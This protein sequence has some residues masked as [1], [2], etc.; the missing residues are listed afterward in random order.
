[1]RADK[2]IAANAEAAE[3]GTA[4]AGDKGK[5]PSG[6]QT[7][8]RGLDIL[9][10]VA[11][12][13]SNL[14]DIAAT[15]GLSRSTVHRLAATLVDQRYLGFARNMGYTLGPKLLELGFLAG[16]QLSLPRIARSHLEELAANSGDTVHLAMLDGTRA[17]YLDK[18]PGRRR[19]EISSRIGERQ[20]LRST[21]I[22]KALILGESEGRWREL[23]D[24]EDQAGS[25]YNV[26]FVLWLKRMRDYAARGYA[27]DLEENE[28]RIRCVAAPVYDASGATI[29]AISISSAAQYMDED[30]MHRLTDEV[31]S[32]A[33]AISH[34]L[35]WTGSQ[36]T[37][38]AAPA[39]PIKRAGRGSA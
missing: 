14:T 27:F 17:L 4:D 9:N 38:V 12:G 26:D 23:Y 2:S 24:L 25:R 8:A 16:R 35:G 15:L 32:T 3:S 7:L 13:V 6:T 18:I 31:R 11:E 37:P 34:E 20:P 19:V 1:L 29:G 28:D 21:G 39:P 30:R 22:G 36:G 5:M 10:A 33:E